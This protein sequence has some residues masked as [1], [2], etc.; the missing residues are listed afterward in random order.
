M[1]GGKVI[2]GRTD[3]C[4]SGISTDSRTARKGDLFI[5]LKG[6]NFDGHDFIHAALKKG[7]AG[8]F[9]SKPLKN[10]PKDKAIIVLPKKPG[11]FYPT[12]RALFSVAGL[13]RKKFG[14][15]IVAVTGSSGKTTTKDMIHAV[16]SK[17]ARTLKTEE[18]F[19]NEIGVPATVFNLNKSHKFAVI[20]MGMQGPGEIEPLSIL[21]SPDVAVI[22]N[23]GEAHL[24]RLKTK[25]AIANAKSEIIR[26]LRTGSSVILNADDGFFNFLRK[27][28]N[29][30]KVISVGINN[31][32]SLKA[33][34]IKGTVD[35]SEF[36]L[37][38]VG[39]TRDFYVPL[40]GRHNIY[41]ALMAVAAGLV[42]KVPLAEIKKGLK[43]FSPSSKRMDIIN[44][45][46]GIKLINDTYNANPSSMAAAIRTLA[47]E[48]GRKVAVIGDMLELGKS[49]RRYHR[50]IGKIA[51]KYRIDLIVAI[52]DQ[53][54]Y[55]VEGFGKNKGF[56]FKDKIGAARFI[57]D[58]LRSGD[59]VLI[60]ASRGL[61]LEE[62]TQKILDNCR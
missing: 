48:K 35:G 31:K 32:A 29:G 53:A 56:H 39:K 24:A 5:P 59:T 6:P 50:E 52:G 51:K 19:N 11:K 37:K 30:K 38:I 41:N 16:L 23:I 55:F 47:G 27:R 58:S 22:T 26:G 12:L 17:K 4:F 60:K 25:K 43:G 20:E 36:K 21:C 10:L 28:A 61:K 7:A 1:T 42:F 13:Y 62:I 8:S 40:P 33:F 34:D 2:S 15:K 54:R 14:T 45:K 57:V 44:A 3:L 9:I 18:N 46:N 49:S